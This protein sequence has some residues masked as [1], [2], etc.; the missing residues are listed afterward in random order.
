MHKE[1]FLIRHASAS[2]T[3][4]LQS[5]F[6]RPLNSSGKKDVC[7]IGKRLKKLGIQPDCI[8]ASAATRTQQ[9]ALELAN[10]LAFNSNNIFLDKTLYHSSAERLLQEVIG[11][12]ST[13]QTAILI[14]HNPGITHFVNSLIPS[15]SIDDMPTCGVVGV[16]FAAHEW[17]EFDAVEKELFLFEYPN[18]SYGSN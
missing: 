3:H 4:S 2:Y 17:Y 11:I 12:A 7:L 14:A 13:I 1:L 8:I 5:D 18:K 6:E 15:F 16:R 9:T 10:E